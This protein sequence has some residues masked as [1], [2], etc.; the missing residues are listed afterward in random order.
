MEQDGGSRMT[1]EMLSDPSLQAVLSFLSDAAKTS[2]AEKLIVV[3]VVWWAMGNKVKGFKDEVKVG[4]ES[5]A[6]EVTALKVTVAKDLA[7]QASRLGAVE[8]G[9]HNLTSKVQSLET[10]KGVGNG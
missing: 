4:L 5:I 6:K 7:M 1:L 3:G 9:I 10:K 8:N 2:I